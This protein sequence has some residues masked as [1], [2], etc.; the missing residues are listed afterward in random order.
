MTYGRLRRLGFLFDLLTWLCWGLV[1]VALAYDFK[2]A[3]VPV[4]FYG[5]TLVL[6]IA[7]G[8]FF[9]TIASWFD[10]QKSALKKKWEEQFG[11][12]SFLLDILKDKLTSEQ[13][14]VICCAWAYE[15]ALSTVSIST[16]VSPS[17][18]SF[19]SLS[20]AHFHT[21]LM[22]MMDKGFIELCSEK[23]GLVIGKRLFEMA[24]C[25]C[26]LDGFHDPSVRAQFFPRLFQ[27]S[28]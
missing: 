4:W 7:L 10:R 20:L 5:M 13:Q 23:G 24:R 25:R 1:V 9:G 14:E 2:N 26:P 3:P 15:D 21:E 8:L 16:M 12:T 6:P 27:V 19:C 22:E 17:F 28:A 11:T 18:S